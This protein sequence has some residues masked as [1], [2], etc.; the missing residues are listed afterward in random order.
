MKK[1]VCLLLI[2]VLCVSIIPV[3]ATEEKLLSEMTDEEC[4]AFV[5]EN[6]ISIPQWYETQ[7]EW[8]PFIR[9]VI[10]EVEE[11]PNTIFG[12]GYVDLLR[13]SSDIKDAVLEHYESRN[14]T[15]S[16][17][18]SATNILQDN[19][20]VHSWVD[21]GAQINC[22]AYAIGEDSWQDPGFMNGLNSVGASVYTLATYA[23]A[24][25]EA[26]GYDAY[27]SS[28]MHTSYQHENVICFRRGVWYS[29]ENYTQ[30]SDYHVMRC[31]MDGYWYH[32][33]GYSYPL[34]YK[35]APNYKDWVHEAYSSNLYK[36]NEDVKY[37]GEIWYVIYSTPHEYE[38]MYCGSNGV[39]K[40]I[41]TCTI[42]NATTGSSTACVF[43]G[44]STKCTICGY[45]KN[46]SVTKVIT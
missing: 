18:S 5:L 10:K 8:A 31:D 7:L 41:Q 12:F 25:L 17:V 1:I 39:H 46:T 38:Y 45:N 27:V 26:K 9:G 16:L 37:T 29:D 33:P 11:N 44:G 13:F 23:Q 21:S 24:D 2:M 20:V 15:R 22:Y 3:K 28:L 34:K 42:C 35:Y 43:K 6:G 32:K 40:H 30:T 36:R 4:V 19:W 14:K